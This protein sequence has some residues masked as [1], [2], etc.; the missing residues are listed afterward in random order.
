MKRRRRKTMR[1]A[2][3]MRILIHNRK[4]K[5]RV[6]VES[7]VWL[8]MVKENNNPIVCREEIVASWS[9]QRRRILRGKID[10]QICN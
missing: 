7:V 3:E 5:V 9:N 8:L 4:L 2:I 6:C 10:I 1:M